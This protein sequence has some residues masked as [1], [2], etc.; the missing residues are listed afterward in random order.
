MKSHSITNG[1]SQ[2]GEP[3]RLLPLGF[4][5][6]E[7]FDDV[8]YTIRFNVVTGAV[9]P[10]WNIYGCVVTAIYTVRAWNLTPQYRDHWSCELRDLDFDIRRTPEQSQ[11]D[12]DAAETGIFLISEAMDTYQIPQTEFQIWKNDDM[13]I[14]GTMRWAEVGGNTEGTVS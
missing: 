2:L 14:R 4:T 11:I 1:E 8:T 10:A 13:V 6:S 12:E 5:Q 7:S 9:I 3:R